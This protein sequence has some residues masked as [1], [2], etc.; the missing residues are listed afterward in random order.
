MLLHHQQS[1]SMH[2]D[3]D[4][5]SLP[6]SFFPQSCHTVFVVSAVHLHVLSCFFV[7]FQTLHL[8]AAALC[9]VAKSD[10]SKNAAIVTHGAYQAPDWAEPP[11]NTEGVSLDVLKTGTILGTVDLPQ[12]SFLTLGRNKE[13]D[14]IAE[15]PSTSRLHAVLQFQGS[16]AYLVDCG[17]THGTSLNQKQLKPFLYHR[18]HV[19]AQFT[20]GQSTRSYIF[21][22]PEVRP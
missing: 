22:A 17:S 6:Q 19:G 10:D 5:Q 13:A 15:H 8:D 16:A 14:V 2:S 20:L 3:H 18:L 21:N 7:T 9:R 12:K 1:H 11:P 4:C